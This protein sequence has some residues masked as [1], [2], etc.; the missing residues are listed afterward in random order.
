MADSPPTESRV[1]FLRT[2]I[3]WFNYAT[4]GTVVAATVYAVV[5]N[6]LR[7]RRDEIKATLLD[8]LLYDYCNWFL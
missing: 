5:T 6:A 4:V 2:A 7:Q 1:T 8:T 3:K